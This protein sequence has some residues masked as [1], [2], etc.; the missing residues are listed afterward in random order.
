[1]IL[2]VSSL[3]SAKE[4]ITS[5]KDQFFLKLTEFVLTNLYSKASIKLKKN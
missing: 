2:D 3:L 5:K 1:M 4:K